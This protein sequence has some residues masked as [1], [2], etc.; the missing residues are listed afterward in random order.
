[1]ND[2]KIHAMIAVKSSEWA[3][4]VVWVFMGYGRIGTKDC[5]GLHGV[6]LISVRRY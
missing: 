5:L 4:K 6:H 2:K 3:R 1:M